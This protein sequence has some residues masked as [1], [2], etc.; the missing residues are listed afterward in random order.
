MFADSGAETQNVKKFR[1]V[2]GCSVW[3]YQLWSF[4]TRDTKLER[5]LHKNQRTQR[6]SLNFENWTNGEPQ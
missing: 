1:Y 2:L 5:F 6:K 4:K 3:H